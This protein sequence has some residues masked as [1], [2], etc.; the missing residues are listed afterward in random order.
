MNGIRNKY[1]KKK[2]ASVENLEV[3]LKESKLRWYGHVLGW[4]EE[5]WRWSYQEEKKGGCP[6]RRFM[7]TVKE[8]MKDGRHKKSDELEK[9][10]AV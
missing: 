10:S 9:E 6:R 4:V 2:T 1:V 7:D 3:K 5:L 8:N